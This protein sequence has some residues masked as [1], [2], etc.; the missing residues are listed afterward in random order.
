MKTI[1]NIALSIVFL[2]SVSLFL[3]SCALLTSLSSSSTTTNESNTSNTNKGKTQGSYDGTVKKSSGSSTNSDLPIFSKDSDK[4][5][6]KTN[7]PKK[8]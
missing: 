8:K 3:P 1:K 6:E 5:S 7:T 2:F 4:S